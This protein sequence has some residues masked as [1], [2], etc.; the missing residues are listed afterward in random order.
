MQTRK[1]S[2]KRIGIQERLSDTQVEQAGS[3][4]RKVRA[5]TTPVT[6]QDEGTALE[7]N[8]VQEEVM[9]RQTAKANSHQG[10]VGIRRTGEEQSEVRERNNGH[11]RTREGG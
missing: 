11:P 2:Q 6:G 5:Q 8:N 1:K 10:N 3:N 7:S 4:Q 9:H